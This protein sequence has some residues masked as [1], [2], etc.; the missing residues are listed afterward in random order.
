MKQ[1]SD[2]KMATACNGEIASDISGTPMPPSALP[3][4]P[5]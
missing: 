4:P 2:S 3:K 5:F 1:R